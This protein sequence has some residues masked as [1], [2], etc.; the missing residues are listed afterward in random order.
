MTN[1]EYMY[2]CTNKS[3]PLQA[4]ELLTKGLLPCVKINRNLGGD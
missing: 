2:S 1:I 4:K 3:V